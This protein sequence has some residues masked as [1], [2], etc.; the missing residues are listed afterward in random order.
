MAAITCPGLGARRL[1]P[2]HRDVCACAG[3]HTRAIV[4]HPTG[5]PLLGLLLPPWRPRVHAAPTAGRTFQTL[6]RPCL[7]SAR[8]P[9]GSRGK[10]SRPCGAALLHAPLAH[11]PTATL[12]SWLFPEHARLLPT[13]GSWPGCS[14]SAWRAVPQMPA[15]RTPSVPGSL[16]PVSSCQPVLSWPLVYTDPIPGPAWCS[17]SLSLPPPAVSITLTTQQMRKWT[18]LLH[19]WFSVSPSPI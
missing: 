3:A 4:H 18:Y 16:C 11:F 6:F 5:C 7:P 14:T 10:S 2:L 12:A 19:L 1:G 13:P 8:D 15:L 17:P 9:W